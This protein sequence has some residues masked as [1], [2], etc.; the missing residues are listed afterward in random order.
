M[1]P[2]IRDMLASDL[3]PRAM[4]RDVQKSVGKHVIFGS[5]STKLVGT[6]LKDVD[7]IGVHLTDMSLIGM[8]LMS[9]YPRPTCISCTC[10]L[11]FGQENMQNA[12][13]DSFRSFQV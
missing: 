10:I 2:A 4:C 5:H 13:R 11:T 12:D 6:H 7:L 3:C 8:H 9:L 1:L